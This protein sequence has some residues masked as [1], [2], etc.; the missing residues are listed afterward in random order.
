[1]RFTDWYVLICTGRSDT[2]VSYSKEDDRLIHFIARIHTHTG[3]LGV[4]TCY[5]VRFPEM[6]IELVKLGAQIMLV[7]AAF[8]VPTGSAHW[9]ILLRGKSERLILPLYLPCL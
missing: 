6:Y 7:P 8:T 4:T 5:D 2:R 9:H 3:R 1:V